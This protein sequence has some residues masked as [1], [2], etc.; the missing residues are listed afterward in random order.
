MPVKQ[1]YVVNQHGEANTARGVRI[2]D[3]ISDSTL[4]SPR[5][6]TSL[7]L[8]R[9]DTHRRSLIGMDFDSTNYRQ[10]HRLLLV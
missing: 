1:Q 9:K 4:S 8:R 10:R 7:Q 2:S 3:P 6:W 5:P